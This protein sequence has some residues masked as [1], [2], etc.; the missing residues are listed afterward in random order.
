MKNLIVIVVIT[1]F[2][3]TFLTLNIIFAQ[4]GKKPI[5]GMWQGEFLDGT[6]KLEDIFVRIYEIPI[7]NQKGYMVSS[8]H[9]YQLDTIDSTFIENNKIYFES[10]LTNKRILGKFNEDDKIWECIREY[11]KKKY[12]FKQKVNLKKCDIVPEW[13][14]NINHIIYK[15]GI[16]EASIEPT[17]YGHCPS[18]RVEVKNGRIVDVLYFEKHD[19]TGQLKDEDYGKEYIEE[20]GELAY[21]AAQLSVKGASIYGPLLILGQDL[22]NIDAVTGA[23]YNLYRFKKVV[24][25]ALKDAILKIE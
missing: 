25:K 11:G 7:Q 3:I 14:S 6:N 10:R 5:S 19:D 9:K 1:L 24:G 23:T 12:L 21:P 20:F 8:G 16:Y 22:N 4:E 18:C 2:V 13:A 17:P 15:D